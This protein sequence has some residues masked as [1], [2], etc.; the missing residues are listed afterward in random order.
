VRLLQLH[1]NLGYA[2]AANRGIQESGSELVAILNNDIILDPEWLQSLLDRVEPPYDFWAS[3]IIFSSQ[4]DRLDSAGDGMAVIG[5][6]FKIG[7]GENPDHYALGGEVFGPCGAAAL[8]RREM[9]NRLD[10]FDEDFFL[11]YEDAD[12]SFRARL[13][14]YRC[15]Y[16]PKARVYHKVN[17]QIGTFSPIYVYYGHRNSEFVFWKNMPTSL[18]VRYL[19]ERLV[20]DLLSFTYF[21]FKG[22]MLSFLRA[23]YD[24][25]RQFQTVLAKRKSIQSSR[26]L[27]PDEL[28]ALLERNWLSYRWKK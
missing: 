9:L 7:H 14:G 5:A 19:P 4:R 26:S 20:F 2:A 1:S 15:L 16:V 10:G 21:S 22:R 27:T 12:L 23:K 25:V 28:S 3:R 24:F 18:L 8:Y 13:A 11:V 17:L 6:G